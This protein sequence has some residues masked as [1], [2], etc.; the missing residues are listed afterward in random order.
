VGCA[1][2]LI[3]WG[4]PFWPPWNTLLSARWLDHDTL[5]L[6]RCKILRVHEQGKPMILVGNKADLADSRAVSTEEGRILAQGWGIPYIETS[7]KTKNNVDKVD[8]R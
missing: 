6:S 7:A 2:L 5:P 8:G 1:A 4:P 3:C